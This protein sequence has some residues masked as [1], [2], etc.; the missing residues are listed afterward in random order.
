H[1]K[2]YPS[3][4]LEST[5]SPDFDQYKGRKA[6]MK[7]SDFLDKIGDEVDKAIDRFPDTLSA[8]ILRQREINKKNI[9]KEF[10]GTEEDWEDYKW[11]YRNIINTKER[12]EK[13]KKIINITKA[14]EDAI[15]NSIENKIPF[16]ITPHYLSLMDKEESSS[17]FPLRMQ[18]FPP[19]KYVDSMLSHSKDKSLA[20]DFMREHDTSPIDSI[21]RRYMKV[22]I[23]KPY[24]TC[25][26]ICV[27]CQRN[28]EITSPNIP[29]SK[30]TLKDLDKAIEWIEDHKHIMDILVTGG[31][32]LIMNNHSIDELL[33]KLSGISHIKS[34]R[35]ASRIP[36]T[37]PQRIDDEFINILKK[38]NIP[39]KRIIYFVT[40]FQDS[41]EISQET[42]EAVKKLTMNGIS[43]YNQQVFTFSN[44]RR[45]ESVALRI[46]LKL[47]GIDPYSTFNM[48]GKEETER[49][50]VPMA[51][52]LQEQ[53][54]EARLFSGLER[55]DEAVYNVPR[56]GK[57]YLRAAQHR[58]LI[59]ILP[60]G[61]RVYEFH[62]WE[63]QMMLQEIFVMPDVPILSY[64][65][66]LD[67]RGEDLLDYESIWYYY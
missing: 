18:V 3:H 16:A 27:Y 1:S 55:T 20:F 41:Y 48:K 42:L 46:A 37:V 9:L 32:P 12:V 64:L 39:G 29:S 45:F 49:L 59:G 21:T 11:H 31:D 34:I 17:D 67:A 44:S 28:W 47:I 13:L 38:Y 66:K 65:E 4:L 54:E 5:V 52:L 6:A 51:R 43:I 23:L 50:H 25:P 36:V 15:V 30:I 58:D 2:V 40:H 57:N 35:I 63:K 61:R 7:R 10:N 22:A 14:Q 8:G 60:D 56:L 33:K 62:P 19:V 53:K 26:Q 24:D